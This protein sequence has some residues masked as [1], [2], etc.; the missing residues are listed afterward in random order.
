MTVVMPVHGAWYG[1]W[2]RDQLAAVEECGQPAVLVGHSMG[3]LVVQKYLERGGAL[4][5]ILLASVPTSGALG[6]TLCFGAWHPLILLRA[7]LVHRH[8]WELPAHPQGV[9]VAAGRS[10]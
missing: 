10:W 9:R 1:T 5:A 8:L 7:N 6:A 2:C 4:G 3:G